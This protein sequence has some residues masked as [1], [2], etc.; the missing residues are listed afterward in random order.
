MTSPAVSVV[1]PTMNREALLPR[2]IDS[3]IAQT[4]TDWEIV[5]VDDGSTDGTPR[6]AR[7][8][9]DRLGD[10]FTYIPQ[11][12]RGSSAARNRGIEASRGRYVAFL[13]S[14]DEFLPEKL[15]RQVALF[16]ARPE[17]GFVYSDFSVID[18]NGA[19][20]DSTFRT[21]FPL[22]LEV[23]AERVSR[24]LYA[25]RKNL[26]DTLVRG[27]F[28]ATIVGMVRREVLG[29]RIRFDENQAYSEEWLFYLRVAYRCRSGFVDEPLA[30]HHVT[31]SSLARQDK[32]RNTRRMYGLLRTLNASFRDMNRG[33]RRAVSDQLAR[34]CR[35]IGYDAMSSGHY[36][37]AL[38]YAAKAWRYKPDARATA[39]VLN[40][41]AECSVA[42]IVSW[43]DKRTKT[44]IPIQSAVDV[45]R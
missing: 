16:D 35:Q 3:V 30:L 2:A 41:L 18:L 38:E 28:I 39:D 14:D 27:Y 21:K 44:S 23:P 40:T 12:H 36:R 9:L 11:D 22:A 31:P 19:R 4:F 25:C 8:Y 5:L 13:D 26:F 42:S 34:T 43:R 24:G 45:V 29:H 20:R 15:R 7:S 32:Q 6:V 10:R 1:I 17:L 37:R 33:Q